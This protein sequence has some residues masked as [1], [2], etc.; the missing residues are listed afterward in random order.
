M[1]LPTSSI[2]LRIHLGESDKLGH[3]PLY[4]AIVEKARS[5]GL[6]GATVFRGSM[7]FGANSLI[8]S[9]KILQLSMDLPVVVEIIDSEEKVRGFLPEIKTM[10][11]GGLVTL[12]HVEVAHYEGHPGDSGG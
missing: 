11:R 5:A 9:S 12:Q 6:A 10:I 7:G 2:L 1:N 4:E 8:H 3:S